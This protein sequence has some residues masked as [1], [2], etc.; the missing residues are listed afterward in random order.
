MAEPRLDTLARSLARGLTRR[1]LIGGLGGGT[2]TATGLVVLTKPALVCQR[3][4]TACRDN[5]PCCRGSTCRD[6]TCQCLAGWEECGESGRCVDPNADADHC[7]RCGRAC[8]ADETCCAG[9]CTNAHRDRANC[10]IC[11]SA[12]AAN[13]LCVLGSC[14]AC[15]L[16]TAPC[17]N[18][19]RP[20]GRCPTTRRAVA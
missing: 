19:C 16:G 2:L 4:G 20:P 17:R 5:Q 18:V 1:R 13:E 7:G 9:Q 3:T 10:G 14:L 8:A 12:C 11:G 15:P 6:G